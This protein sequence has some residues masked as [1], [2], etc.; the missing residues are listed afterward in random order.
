M[1]EIYYKKYL[2]YKTKYLELKGGLH[3]ACSE[4]NNNQNIYYRNFPILA[5]KDKTGFTYINAKYNSNTKKY[6]ARW[7]V[8]PAKGEWTL[9]ENIIV[10]KKLL[11]NIQEVLDFCSCKYS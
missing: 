2:K 3:P 9:D 6:T 11:K 10:E 1:E 4:L 7:C 8:N 5:I